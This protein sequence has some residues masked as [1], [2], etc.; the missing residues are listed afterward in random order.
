[1]I[2]KEIDVKT[3]ENY[4]KN[5]PYQT[6]MQTKQI[7]KLREINGWEIYYLGL[8]DNNKLVG[9]T[10]LV[11][12]KR[13]FNKYEFYAPRGPLLDYNNEKVLTSFLSKLIEFVK[14]HNGYILRIDPYVIN[15]ERNGKGE[16]IEGGID[17]TKIVEEI[18]SLG[19]NLLPFK[20]REQV[21]TMYVLDTKNKTIEEIFNN[22][23]SSTK[24][25]INKTLK[26][27][28]EIKEITEDRLDEF[29]SI[30]KETGERKGFDIRDNN[31]Y[32]RMYKIFKDSNGI[33]YLIAVINLKDLLTKL[34]QEKETLLKKQETI[35]N[36]EKNQGKIK[37]L[38]ENIE[39]INKRIELAIKEEKEHGENITLAGS[40]FI[41]TKKEVIYLAGG[42]HEEFLHYNAQ[43]LIQWE[44]IKYAIENGYDRYNFYGIPDKLDENSKDY[45]V[46]KF[47]T[48]FNGYVEELIGE[49]EIKASPIYYLIRLIHKIR[50]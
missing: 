16:V 4:A 44:M 23:N 34:N 1:M 40:M 27:G 35:E 48:G 33:K 14:K 18:K 10:L 24:N 31:Y 7:G 19:F 42:N 45:G 6:F 20:E 12:K 30:M 37:A 11:S 47:K 26:N 38:T 2:L 25:K 22:M 13:H 43:Y 5:N 32:K 29:Y 15:K 28:I 8:Y 50:H 21:S 46:Y 17:N 49:F 3:F 9:A 39:S 41:L 36:N